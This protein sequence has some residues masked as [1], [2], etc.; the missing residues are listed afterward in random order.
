MENQPKG[1]RTKCWNFSKKGNYQVN[2][3]ETAVILAAGRGSRLKELSLQHPKPMTRINQVSIIENLVKNLIEMKLENIVLV[4]GYLSDKLIS[5][6]DKRFSEQANLTYIENPIYDKTNNIYS[7]WLAEKY[8]RQGFFLFE[9]D[10]FFEQRVAGLLLEHEADNIILIDRYR[11]EMEGTVVDLDANSMV[12]DMHLKRHQ[13]ENF[14]FDN[15]YKT[16]NF[17]KISQNFVDSFFMKKLNAHIERSDVNSYYELI[18]KE[19]IDE[20][21]QFFGLET[22]GM[23]W[24]EIDTY[25][26][27]VMAED[28]FL[29]K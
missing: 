11:P 12:T 21:F 26:D 8:L 25:E 18:I 20:G 4:V 23:K 13:T 10:V 28:I 9:A 2:K 6:L 1:L 19:A 3:V 5:H 24:W 7:L 27:L 15:R 29:Q 14:K 22:E 16:I 17:Y